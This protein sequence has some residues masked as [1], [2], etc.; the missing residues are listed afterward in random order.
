LTG[1]IVSE[2]SL[3]A[4]QCRILDV[5]IASQ[6]VAP[7]AHDDPCLCSEAIVLKLKKGDP[8]AGGNGVGLITPIGKKNT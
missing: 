3:T 1:S 6:V 7:S 5:G 2:H 8:M 4:W